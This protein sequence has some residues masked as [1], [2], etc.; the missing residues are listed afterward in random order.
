MKIEEIKN[1]P[2][3]TLRYMERYVNSGSPSGFTK[4]NT[5]SRNTSPFSDNDAFA[6]YSMYLDEEDFEI[7]GEIDSSTI[8]LPKSEMLLHPD[9]VSKAFVRQA[10]EPRVTDYR[11]T[12]TS[13]GRTV[14]FLGDFNNDYIKLHY[15]G[16]IGRIDRKLPKRK[17]INGIEISSIIIDAIDE[18]KLPSSLSIFREPYAK[19]LKG[20]DDSS[21][22]GAVWRDSHPTGKTSGKIDFLIPLFSL[23]SLDTKSE[24]DKTI[25]HQLCELWGSHS[26]SKITHE[27]IIPLIDSYFSLILNLGLQ[28]E[29]NAQN[30]LIGFD[31]DYNPVSVSIRDLMGIEK[32]YTLRESLG[33]SNRFDASGYKVICASK[34]KQ[35]WQIRHSFA[36]DF[37]FS[38]Y[39]IMPIVNLCS[40]M[41]IFSEKEK[42]AEIK[43]YI[44]NTWIRQLPNN[45]FPGNRSWYLHENTLLTREKKYISKQN[46]LLR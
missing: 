10:G 33:L 30:F 13:S 25:F 22:W 43:D 5:T 36:F 11:V 17:A 31:S 24:T 41:R 6:L 7:Y 39:V 18:D 46:P 16:V 4:K 14:Q 44:K 12:P 45:Y 28:N 35:L 2:D 37:K 34:N 42:I 1:N 23:W 26:E 19:L 20:A 27:I 3:I 29:A 8:S 38:H 40:E 9:M 21:S 15:D 32:D